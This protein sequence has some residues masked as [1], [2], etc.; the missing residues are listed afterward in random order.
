M[1]TAGRGSLLKMA[2]WSCG[3]SVF[4]SLFGRVYSTIDRSIANSGSLVGGSKRRCDTIAYK[5]IG[6]KV[7][8]FVEGRSIAA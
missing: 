3:L 7:K 1:L 4:L 6:W 2:L 5:E 8:F